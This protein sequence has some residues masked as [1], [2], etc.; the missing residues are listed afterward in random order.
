MLLINPKFESLKYDG[1]NDIK[2][3]Y[4]G[5]LEDI[6]MIHQLVK[7]NLKFKMNRNAKTIDQV[8][9]SYYRSDYR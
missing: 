6:S 1:G 9:G 4:T 2:T 5:W 8:A 7:S 3:D